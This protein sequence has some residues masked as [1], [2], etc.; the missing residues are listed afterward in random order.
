M[1]GLFVAP[2]RTQRS[3]T[4]HDPPGVLEQRSLALP[5]AIAEL[6]PG[7]SRAV[8]DLGPA[9]GRSVDF[10]STAFKKMYIADVVSAFMENRTALALEQALPLGGSLRFDLVIAWDLFNF[11]PPALANSL[12]SLLIDL[13]HPHTM[14]FAIRYRR[15]PLP[16]APQRFTIEAAERIVRHPSEPHTPPGY[17][18][19]VGKATFAR[20][21]SPFK[22]LHS[23]RLCCGIDEELFTVHAQ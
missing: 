8:L 16:S 13:A 20:M 2:S 4:T 9:S 23:Y 3:P 21:L 1:R 6:G 14:L 19:V 11:V 22:P 17:D 7:G 12:A 15:A 5:A 10:Y 18:E